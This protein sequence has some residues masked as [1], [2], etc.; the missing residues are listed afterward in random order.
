MVPAHLLQPGTAFQSSPALLSLRL[1]ACRSHGAQSDAAVCPCNSEQ[2]SSLH[3]NGTEQLEPSVFLGG[4][5]Q[6]SYSG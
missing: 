4:S 5:P 3:P 6:W 2:L 1:R